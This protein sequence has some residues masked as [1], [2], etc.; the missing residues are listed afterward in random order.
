MVLLDVLLTFGVAKSSYKLPVIL[1]IS[2]FV[3]VNSLLSILVYF[4][5][6]DNPAFTSYTPW[7]RS[8]LIGIAYI[9]IVRTKLGG[10]K[11]DDKEIPIGIDLLYGSFKD[12]AYQAI[13][14][15]IIESQYEKDL[16]V[17][18]EY[19]LKDL[20]DRVK[21]RIQYSKT[22]RPEQKEE[23][24]RWLADVLE[25]PNSDNEMQKKI[26]LAH[27][28]NFIERPKKKPAKGP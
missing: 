20:A 7:I 4:L 8:I 28:L 23:D 26:F 21:Y 6:Y 16:T 3:G 11:R 5:F 2:I 10:I 19:S 15:L 24:K 27:Y 17:A 9:L 13:D 18:K 14:S 25:D 12:L 22:L 1:W